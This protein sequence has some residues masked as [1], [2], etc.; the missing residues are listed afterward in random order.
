MSTTTDTY[1]RQ[2]TEAELQASVVKMAG[3]CGWKCYHTKFSIGSDRGF[4]DLILVRPPRLM[5]FE[6]KR[7][8]K[9]P[10]AAQDAWLEAIAACGI[11]TYVFTPFDWHAG[12]IDEV[13]R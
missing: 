2:M 5:A 11:E 10:T 6:F 4:P 8:G 12:T 3:Y 13:L 1:H 9:H 7:D